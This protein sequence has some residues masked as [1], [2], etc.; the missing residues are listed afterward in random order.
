MK[1]FIVKDQKRRK[2]IIKTDI[3]RM[4]LKAFQSNKLLPKRYRSAACKQLYRLKFYSFSKVK[5][6][7]QFTYR[8]RSVYREF[9]VSRHK[10]RELIS[11]GYFVG[12]EKTGW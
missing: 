2:K 9:K 10:L 4:F 7:C 1:S 6:R 8:G 12:V 5:N 3:N 11:F